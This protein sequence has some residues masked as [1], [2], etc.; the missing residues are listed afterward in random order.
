MSRKKAQVPATKT[1][2]VPR[3]KVSKRIPEPRVDLIPPSE[4]ERRYRI[5]LIGRWVNAVVLITLLTVGLIL[6][7]FYFNSNAS[8][9]LAAAE[10]QGNALLLQIDELAE[11]SV[12]QAKRNTLLDFREA[13]MSNHLVFSSA[14]AEI[15]T[16]LP[17]GSAVTA[18][19]L[20][21]G[22]VASAKPTEDTGMAVVLTVETATPMN[23]VTLTRNL[24]SVSWVNFAEAI[25]L[26]S[27]GDAEQRDLFL[28]TVH[29]RAD[30]TIY[31]NKFS[32]TEP[33]Q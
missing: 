28:Y 32:S 23:V 22:G 5:K 14:L 7:T 16:H 19:E 13:A 11:V 27:S 26:Q 2:A 21:T 3:A 9:E 31:S 17:Q 25:A 18:V 10:E 4:I 29:V 33:T 1:I 20:V 12:A 15:M 6:G 8:V 30:Q 24:R